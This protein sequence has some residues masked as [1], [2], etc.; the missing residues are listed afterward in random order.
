MSTGMDEGGPATV[1]PENGSCVV[2]GPDRERRKHIW[3]HSG[4]TRDRTYR[5]TRL[6]APVAV[7]MVLGAT[8][9]GLTASGT[10]WAS[11]TR[12]RSDV[13]VATA[14]PLS[15]ASPSSPA[16]GGRDASGLAASGTIVCPMMPAGPGASPGSVSPGNATHL[17]TRTTTDGVTIRAYRLPQTNPCTCGP[18]PVSSPPSDVS[19]GSASSGRQIQGTVSSVTSAMSVELSDE[20]AVGQGVL[21]D[22]PSTEATTPTGASA[23]SEP[24]AATSDSFGVAEGAPVWWI[25]VS[26]GPDVANVRVT[27]SDG[28]TDQM[29]PI[30]GVAVLA[31]Q[32]DPSVAAAGDGPYEV[33]ASLQLLGDSGTVIDAVPFPTPSPT[34]VPVP[35]PAPTPAPAPVPVPVPTTVPATPPGTAPASTSSTSSTS[36]TSTT[37]VPAAVSRPTIGAPMIACP[38]MQ[39]SA[40]ASSG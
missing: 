32:I 12:Q 25:A 15:S 7:A 13:H 27:F 20:T 24:I 5:R 14:T 30:S 1:G 40:A 19:P 16:S 22:P 34:P 18:I 36:P 6:V 35:T 3:A 4:P 38:V 26:V 17:F 29:S 8:G 21:A 2:A 33:R 9:I 11:A 28:S 31:H 10:L 23:V 37:S 39:S